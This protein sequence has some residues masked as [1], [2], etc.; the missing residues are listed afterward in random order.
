MSAETALRFPFWVRLNAVAVVPLPAGPSYGSA[1]RVPYIAWM[2]A[3]SVA[4]SPAPLRLAGR[5]QRGAGVRDEPDVNVGLVGPG[6]VGPED[7]LLP[8]RLGGG[9]EERGQ[10]ARR[11]R[12]GVCA[13]RHEAERQAPRVVPGGVPVRG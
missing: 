1:E 6:L 3:T 13:V 10:G 5:P 8:G 11:A 9:P 4:D 12:A 7:F 2:A